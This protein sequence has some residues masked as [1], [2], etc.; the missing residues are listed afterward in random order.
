MLY[1]KIKYQKSTN[2]L[3]ELKI[4]RHSSMRKIDR[5]S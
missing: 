3:W 4:R 2:K 1:K 5:L